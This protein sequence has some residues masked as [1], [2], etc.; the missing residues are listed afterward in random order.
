MMDLKIKYN[1]K[2]SF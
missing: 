1:D 2:D